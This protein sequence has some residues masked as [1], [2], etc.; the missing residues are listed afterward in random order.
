MPELSI[1]LADCLENWSR[2]RSNNSCLPARE[3]QP[4][5]S[6]H[7]DDAARAIPRLSHA[8]FSVA[9]QGRVPAA[10]VAAQAVH[11]KK[12]FLRLNLSAA[13]PARKNSVRLDSRN[14]KPPARRKPARSTPQAI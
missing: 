7:H 6:S 5:S 9:R 1:R 12:Y 13:K 2:P 14:V 8:G 3:T 4:A 11:E 10:A